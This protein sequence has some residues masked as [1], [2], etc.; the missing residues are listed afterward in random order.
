MSATN[1]LI[2][3]DALVDHATANGFRAHRYS[4]CVEL[5][6]PEHEGSQSSAWWYGSQY[7]CC[8]FV[9]SDRPSTG[10]GYNGFFYGPWHDGMVQSTRVA[11]LLARP[12]MLGFLAV[13]S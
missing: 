9:L 6:A 2:S 5:F 13:Q 7:S 11:R 8:D 4:G 10:Y 12:E 1:P 3:I